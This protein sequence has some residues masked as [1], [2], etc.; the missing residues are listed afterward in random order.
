VDEPPPPASALDCAPGSRV[1]RAWTS[2]PAPSISPMFA[3]G[4][5][6]A[7]AL[8]ARCSL[9]PPSS[10]SSAKRCAV[11]RAGKAGPALGG[12]D[13]DRWIAADLAGCCSAL[14]ARCWKRLNSSNASSV[15]AV[16]YRARSPTGRTQPGTPRLRPPGPWR[17]C[18][19]RKGLLQLLAFGFCSRRCS[20]R[21]VR[22]ASAWQTSMRC[23]RWRTPAHAPDRAA[24]GAL[25]RVSIPR[26]THVE[27]IA[28]RC[29]IALTPGVR[30][31]DV[32]GKVFRCVAGNSRSE[33]TGWLSLFHRSQRVATAEPLELVA[34]LQ[35]RWGGTQRQLEAGVGEPSQVEQR[36][37][38]GSSARPYRASAR[39]GRE[40]AVEPWRAGTRRLPWKR[41]EAGGWT[42]AIA[43][44]DST[45]AGPNDHAPVKIWSAAKSTKP[46]SGLGSVQLATGPA[47]VDNWSRCPLRRPSMMVMPSKELVFVLLFALALRHQAAPLLMVGTD[48]G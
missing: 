12:R 42:A 20:Q 43:F 41:P 35:A 29:A 5:Q 39:G 26:S 8:F 48:S 1:L 6:R 25:C 40:S 34:G 3:L 44:R 11:A 17:S 45:Q 22:R 37:R 23:L 13:L 36:G 28:V 47:V 4:G 31:K 32:L 24:R 15:Q 9:W 30:I 2:A 38:G 16:Q 21:D 14:G 7:G 46:D 10:G 19:E 18:S 27:A 33:A